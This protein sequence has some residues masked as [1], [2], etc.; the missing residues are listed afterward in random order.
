MPTQDAKYCI[1]IIFILFQIWQEE[2][3]TCSPK[4]VS[5]HDLQQILHCSAQA[6][7]DLSP[8]TGLSL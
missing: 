1:C 3:L 4:N 8:E 5:N 6:P 2:G 7:A